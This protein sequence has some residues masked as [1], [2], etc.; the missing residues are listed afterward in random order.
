M[1][2]LDRILAANAH[3]L[4]DFLPL[5]IAGTRYGCV[6]RDFGETLAR[7]PEVFRVGRARHQ[8]ALRG[9][10][11]CRSRLQDQRKTEREPLS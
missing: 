1:S 6:R 10:S 3:T 9:P 11:W 5:S 7:W 2:F 4:R 8:R